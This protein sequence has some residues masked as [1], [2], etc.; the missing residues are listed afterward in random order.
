MVLR[1]VREQPIEDFGIEPRIEVIDG[2]MVRGKLLALQIKS[3][4]SFPGPRPRLRL[5][6]LTY[7]ARA[8]TSTSE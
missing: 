6:E 8:E 2:E 5:N 1:R 3:G 7:L 4:K